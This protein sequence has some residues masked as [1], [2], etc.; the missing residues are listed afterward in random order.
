MCS[1]VLVSNDNDDATEKEYFDLLLH[2]LVMSITTVIQ[3]IH[4]Y[5]CKTQAYANS[6]NTNIQADSVVSGTNDFINF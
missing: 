5:K 2:N 4:S 6:A 3:Y 1:L